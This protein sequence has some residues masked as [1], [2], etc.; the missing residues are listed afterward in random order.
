MNEGKKKR[1]KERAYK[2][3]KRTFKMKE[4][5]VKQGKITCTHEMYNQN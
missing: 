5:K 4:E 1:N 2:H 3:T